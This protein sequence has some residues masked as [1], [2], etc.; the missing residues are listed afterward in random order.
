MKALLMHK[1][2]DFDLQ[3]ELP[4]NEAALRQDLE[5]D[6]I[7]DAMAHED[8]FLFE[9][10]RVALLSGLDN[11]IETISYR[12]A[13][14]QDALNNPEVVRSLYALAVEAIDT[15]RNQRLGIFS[16]NPSAIL[17]GAINLVWMFTGILEKL[18]NVARESIEMFE[19]EAFSS[20]FTMLDHELSEEYLASIRDRLQEL[21]FR[22]GV[23]VSVELGM[24]NEARN[25]VLTRQKDKS[26]MQ[27]V[28][29]KHSPSYSLSI[30]PRDQAGGRA[31]WELRDRGLNLAVNALA[32]SA[33]HMLSF[34]RMLRA[35]LAFY[36]G[37]LNLY[38]RLS[39]KG[40]PICTPKPSPVGTRRLSFAGLYDVCLTLHT[41][42]RVVG[43][44]VDADGKSLV[45]ITGAN[46]GGKSTFLQSIGLAQLMM[47]CGMFVG[48]ESF[49][50]ELCTG[51]FTH[52]KREED[53]SMK[54]GKFDEEISR[55]SE[56]ADGIRSNSIVL[57]NESFAATN[58][59]EG[60]EIARQ[61]VK[62]LLEKNIRVFFVTHLYELARGLF[63]HGRQDA[64]FLRAERL[65]DGTRTFRLIS[66]EPLAT[67]Y[68]EDLYRQ[69]FMPIGSK[70]A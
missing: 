30:N 4:R 12:Q 8:E 41:D 47:Q 37:S 10:A 42:D 7:L 69:I 16:R 25:Y 23:S 40:E 9:V 35:E 53:A 19:S 61:I 49:E 26:F 29:G 58:E 34:F 15:K 50:G 17:G 1:E 31:L 67:S 22:R 70:T 21:K 55:M 11:D 63:E 65:E 48:A 44:T 54:S 20:L 39:E 52:Y 45:M 27:Q 5:L 13:A 56:I 38:E 2:K 32:Q 33:D 60:S 14:M 62:A 36:V 24:G 59:R 46:R 43:N 68:G 18:R 28:F 6:T 66:G 57:F 3:Q 64:L 51:L